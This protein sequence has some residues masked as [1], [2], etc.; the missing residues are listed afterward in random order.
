MTAEG[1]SIIKFVLGKLKYFFV[2]NNS[3][4]LNIISIFAFFFSNLRFFCNNLISGIKVIL[5]SPLFLTINPDSS[6][7]LLIKY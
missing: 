5:K 1:E 6:S 2:I 3:I 4:S 7:S